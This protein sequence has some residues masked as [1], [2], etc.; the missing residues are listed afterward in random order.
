M[1]LCI[2]TAPSAS[3]R[4]TRRGGDLDPNLALDPEDPPVDETPSEPVPTEP[5][6]RDAADT[7]ERLVGVAVQARLLNDAN[8]A[9]RAAEFNVLTA[10][11]EM[12]RSSVERNPG[13]LN[14]QQADRIVDSR[15]RTA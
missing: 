15:R 2:R 1:L 12:K 4:R 5:R 11:N 13:Q 6:L 3:A 7:A 10:E 8:Y 14:F 9:A